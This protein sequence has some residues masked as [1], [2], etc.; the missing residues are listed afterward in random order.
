METSVLSIVLEEQIQT[1]E[2]AVVVGYGTSKKINLTGSVATVSSSDLAERPIT[3]ASSALQG[4]VPGL[5]VTSGQGRP[6]AGGSIRIRGVG[7]LNNADPYI[8]IDGFESGTMDQ[9]DPNDIASISVLKDAASA[10][11]YGSKAAN[12]V[13][14]ITTKRGVAGKS[15][16]SYNG[17]MGWQD[18]T[19]FVERMNS[20]DA[21]TYYNRALE[22][23]GKAPRFSKE[24]I[25]KFKDGSD[26]Y[27]YPNT[28]W[29]DL[30]YNGSG[31]MHQHNV[32]LSGGVEKVKYMV[33]TGLLDQ[34]G[35]LRHSGRDQFNLRTNLDAQVN[36]QVQVRANMAY[37]N[38]RTT[39]PTSSYSSGG[40]GDIIRQLNRI[41][42]WIPYRYE[43]GSYGTIGDGN[44]I[45]WLDLDQSVISKNQNFSGI[46]A[47][48]YKPIQDLT[49][50]AQG[51]YISNIQDRSEFVKDIQY[52]SSKYHGPNS[53]DESTTLW[54]RSS[55]DLLANYDKQIGQH[56]IKGLL[57]YHMEKYNS[58]YNRAYREG[59]PNNDMNNIDAGTLVT[60]K[61]NGYTRELAM[62]SYFG[63]INY[64][65]AGKYL[66]EA[67]FR[68]DASSRFSPD[69]RWGYFPSLSAG[70]VVSEEDFMA[71]TTS[72]LSSLKIRGSWGQLGN[73]E[74]LDDF[75]PWLVTYG[76]GTNYP[77]DGNVLTGIGQR[78]HKLSTISWERSENTGIGLDFRLFSQLDF[79]VDFY[80][81]KTKGIIMDVPVPGSFGLGAYK[82]N[83]GSMR[84]SGI[85]FSSTYRKKWNDW[86]L[87]ASGNIAFNK[88]E[89]LDLGGVNEMINGYS[90]NRVG[91][92][93]NSFYGYFADGLFQS[94]G[95]ADDF[96]TKFGNPFGNKFE[97]GDIRYKDMN[98]D[99]KLNAADRII[100]GAEQ[101][102]VT[103][104]LNLSTSWKQFDLSVF[105]QGVSGVHRYFSNE[106]YGDFSG[107]TGHPA[108]AWF[109][110]W[111][112]EHTSG[113]FPRVAEAGRSNSLPNTISS[114]WISKANYLRIKNIQLG[115]SLPEEWLKK[116]NIT[117]AKIFYSGENLLNFNSLPVNVDPES[118]SGGGSH[119][120]Q[121]STHS[122]GLNLTF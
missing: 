31:F 120:P 84:N 119:Y 27:N 56:H 50:T 49:L 95:E 40:S 109:D 70:W 47:L 29:N 34:T 39:D 48:D 18:A 46:L 105:A 111:S 112:P 117:R 79:T 87:T 68:A 9:L 52:N 94:Q 60:Q 53:L 14:L 65:Y 20:A 82:D 3:T 115:Y 59:F 33:S 106:V 67:N 45:A 73:Q 44:P 32:N 10:A 6:G 51:A 55:L 38:N 104:G 43:D 88:N 76:I 85:E 71:G 22:V 35:V 15:S 107:D 89:I 19:G 24:E 69:N 78:S 41:A 36:E 83:V 110:A 23:S 57:G 99:G 91:N 37:I 8:L 62:M 77:F 74:A 100:V 72:W 102:K 114:F 97:P 108:T 66:F 5:T 58:K 64:D 122:I 7:T 30:G 118:P 81:R 16:V 25:A 12:G 101:P 75:Y 63:R 2:A 93:I 103:Y 80:Q 1:L 113:K 61:A 4:L 26:P 21:A 96:T 92:A 13:I 121:V 98:N 116:A 54:N 86:S 90:I 42:P 28:N 17:Y 11:I